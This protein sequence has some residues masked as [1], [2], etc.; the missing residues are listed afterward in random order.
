MAGVGKTRLAREAL[1][2]A[3]QR[4]SLT[5]WAVATASA[6][7]LP[8]GACAATLGWSGVWQWSGKPPRCSPAAEQLATW[9]LVAAC[10]GLGRIDGLGERVRRIDARVE[11]F[12]TGL[13]E[14]AVVGSSWVRGLLLAGRLDEA[15]SAAPPKPQPPAPTG[16]RRPGRALAP[17]HWPRSPDRCP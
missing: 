9:G 17:P 3:G 12:Q 13:H 15:A 4:G 16:W 1:A 14:A 5:R 11:S 2:A 6:R 10:G 8:L 7:A